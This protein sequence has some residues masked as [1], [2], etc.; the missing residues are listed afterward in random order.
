MDPLDETREERLALEVSVVLLEVLLR[1]VDH[2]G[3]DELVAPL[4]EA[5]NN[6]ADE[7]TLDAVGLDHDESYKIQRDVR[8]LHSSSEELINHSL[9]SVAILMRSCHNEKVMF[10]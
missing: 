6:L 8:G 9:C 7:A 1:G 4:L 3:V 5:A 2:L 10:G